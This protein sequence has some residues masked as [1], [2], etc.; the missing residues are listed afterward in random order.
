MAAA[1][2]AFLAMRRGWLSRTGRPQPVSPALAMVILA[3]H[4]LVTPSLIR[5]ALWA[6]GFTP[7]A[8]GLPMRERS[9]ELLVMYGSALPVVALWVWLR[10]RPS[11]RR[12]A[13]QALVRLEGADLSRCRKAPRL[14]WTPLIAVAG[15]LVAW[16]IVMF[17]GEVTGLIY[18]HFA[19]VPRPTIAHR[20]LSELAASPTGDPWLLAA[21]SVLVVLVPVLEEIV[22]RGAIQGVLRDFTLSPWPGI[23]LTALL[24]GVMH[25]GPADGI[26][27][28]GLIVFG[29]ALGIV[30]ERFGTLLAPIIM[31]GLFNLGNIALMLLTRSGG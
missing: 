3:W 24:F 14:A 17:T 6:T 5:L 31:H 28:P 11:E 21:V 13:A 8:S 27:V 20:T 16:P 29:I 25:I 4:L 7:G 22:Y 10:R 30:Y 2:A 12:R 23:L 26:A 15:L 19:G 1:F 9:L 18:E